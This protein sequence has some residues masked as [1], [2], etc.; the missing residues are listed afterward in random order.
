MGLPRAT[1]KNGV[2]GR[3]YKRDAKGTQRPSPRRTEKTIE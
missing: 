3:E 1:G 2:V